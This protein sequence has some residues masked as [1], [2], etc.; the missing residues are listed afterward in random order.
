MTR[1]QINI[2]H[3]S[4][5]AA[6]N[7]YI[8]TGFFCCVILLL[9]NLVWPACISAAAVPWPM[10]RHD[11]GRTGLSTYTAVANPGV[12]PL[13]QYKEPTPFDEDPTSSFDRVPS[14]E[15]NML[16]SPDNILNLQ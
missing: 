9:I 4:N 5:P 15:G 12:A 8:C 7:H 13:F 2:Q 1:V 14:L 6:E 10:V 11:A 16:I 3:P